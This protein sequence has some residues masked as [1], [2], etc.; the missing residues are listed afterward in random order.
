MRY[1]ICTLETLTLGVPADKTERIIAAPQTL[2]TVYE[3]KDGDVFI[4]LPA[5]LGKKGK[6]EEENLD[7]GIVFKEKAGTGQWVL[8]LPRIDR[9]LEI[10]QEQIRSLPNL[11]RSRLSCFSGAYFTESSAQGLILLLDTEQVASH[12]RALLNKEDS[13]GGA[14]TGVET[15]GAFAEVRY[16]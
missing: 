15:Q 2:E 10:P 8:L 7:H 3:E 13:A 6:K 9:D 4:S 5:F 12:V 11:L 1:F 16:D 14:E